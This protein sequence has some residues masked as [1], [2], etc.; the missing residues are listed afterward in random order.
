MSD[1]EVKKKILAFLRK[2]HPKDLSIQEISNGIGMHRNS[3]SSYVKVLEA[4][5]KLIVT[6]TIGNNIMYSVPIN[7]KET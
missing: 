5:D 2:E 6:R 3:V 4:E 1:P 7:Q